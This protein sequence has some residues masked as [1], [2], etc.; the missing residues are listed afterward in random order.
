MP[1]QRALEQAAGRCGRQGQPGSVNIYHSKDDYYFMSKA[2]D[3]KEHNLWITQNKLVEYLHN[4]YSF[5][6]KGKGE[7]RIP[8]IELPSCIPIDNVLEICSFKIIRVQNIFTENKEI[9]ILDYIL[10]MVKITW[11]LLFN[12]LTKDDECEKL[13]YCETKLNEYLNYLKKYIPFIINECKKK[14]ENQKNIFEKVFGTVKFAAYG[15]SMVFCPQFTPF[16]MGGI[17]IGKELIDALINDETINWKKVFVKG[18]E[19]A[20]EGLPLKSVVTKGITNIVVTPLFEFTEAKIDGKDYNLLQGVNRKILDQ[21]SVMITHG[22]SKNIEKP[23]KEALKDISFTNEGLKKMIEKFNKLGDK[24]LLKKINEE[25]K[26]FSRNLVHSYQEENVRLQLYT[27]VRMLDEATGS[28]LI[29]NSDIEEE[30]FDNTLKKAYKK[31][32]NDFRG[33]KHN[34][35]NNN[36]SNN[37]INKGLMD[38]K[39]SNYN[40]KIFD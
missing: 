25:I 6:F 26:N 4:Q 7:N 32:V 37:D 12:E 5:L 17:N 11:G 2:F 40:Y 9:K 14:L 13:S 19:G 23:V 21:C 33:K 30:I 35:K 15:L 34:K 22:L 3:I 36:S 39:N 20:F 1:N 10:D 27:T 29:G 16:I 18:G 24:K 28:S 8:D 31:T 38:I